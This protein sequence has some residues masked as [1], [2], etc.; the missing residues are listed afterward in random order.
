MAIAAL[1]K[2]EYN[3]EECEKIEAVVIDATK[4]LAASFTKLSGN[5]NN[6]LNAMNINIDT[7]NKRIEAI[8][9]KIDATNDTI[10]VIKDSV[11]ELKQKSKDKED[12]NCNRTRD[13]VCLV[14]SGVIGGVIGYF[15]NQIP[16][17]C[18]KFVE[19]TKDLF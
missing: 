17:L 2:Q 6:A 16:P 10:K 19:F 5:V 4:E 11:D 8:F 3:C 13:G 12:K 9:E 7:T 14:I 1:D 18:G 15:V